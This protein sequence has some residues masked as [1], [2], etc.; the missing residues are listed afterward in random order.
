MRKD[1]LHRGTSGCFLSPSV[2]LER[3]LL[4]F[5]GLFRLLADVTKGGAVQI[6]ERREPRQWLPGVA[7]GGPRKQVPLY[8][9]R[10]QH[11][12]SVTAAVR[13]VMWGG[14]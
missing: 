13:A 11:V 5:V 1:S 3:P 8:Q 6:Q 10:W 9:V 7:N 4:C 12:H 14:D 2:F